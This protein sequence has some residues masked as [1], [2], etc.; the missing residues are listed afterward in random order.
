MNKAHEKLALLERENSYHLM[1]QANPNPMWICD[2]DSLKFLAVNDAA[3]AHYGYSEADFLAMTILDIR[4][5]EDIPKL[6]AKFNNLSTDKFHQAG[7]WRHKKKD[8]TLIDVEITKHS[9]MFQGRQAEVVLAHDVTQRNL[10]AQSLQRENEKYLALLHNASDGIH[11]VDMN[12]NL[13][14]VSNSFCTMLGYQREELIGMNVSQWDGKFNPDEIRQLVKEQYLKKGRSQF[15]T[16]H[17]RKDGSIFEVEVSGFPLELEGKP[18]LFNSSRDITER[19]QAEQKLRIA[20]IAFESQEGMM[21]ADVTNRILQ[22]NKAFTRITG[23]SA[24]NGQ[25]KP[26]T[27][28]SHFPIVFPLKNQRRLIA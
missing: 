12:C 5:I 10:A 15:E 21:I 28:L 23:Y 1:F 2:L 3:I 7:V 26:D 22:V 16:L 9:I 20:A 11:I 13:I 14:E 25:V 17:R 27:F 6:I 24:C 8:G 4:P 19:K 18:V